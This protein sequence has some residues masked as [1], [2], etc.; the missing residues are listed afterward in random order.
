MTSSPGQEPRPG[1]TPRGGQPR[2]GS[3]GDSRWPNDAAGSGD[4]EDYWLAGRQ[5]GARRPDE[6]PSFTPGSGGTR[7]PGR[8]RPDSTR[9]WADDRDRF[10]SD[11]TLASS[12]FPD[13]TI[14]R[15]GLSA[16]PGLR[17]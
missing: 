2:P 11:P 16:I 7:S 3:G 12:R 1:F 15:S 14:V 13:D 6:R 5:P 8:P 4:V 17:W 10:R 9:R